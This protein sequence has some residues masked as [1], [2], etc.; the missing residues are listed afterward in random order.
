MRPNAHPA[1][2]P[3]ETGTHPTSPTDPGHLVPEG[4]ESFDVGL[5]PCGEAV[6]WDGATD[7]W[8]PDR[9]LRVLVLTPGDAGYIRAFTSGNGYA[10]VSAQLD[11][12]DEIAAYQTAEATGGLCVDCGI[13]PALDVTVGGARHLCQQCLD[14]ARRAFGAVPPLGPR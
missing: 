9:T 8:V 5:C 14:R 11:A 6:R 13:F 3:A 1:M 2:Y 10:H 4:W 12:Q 7:R